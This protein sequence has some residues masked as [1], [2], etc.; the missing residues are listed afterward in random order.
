MLHE[1]RPDVNG[2][3]VRNVPMQGDEWIDECV[4]FD[5]FVLFCSGPELFAEGEMRIE[6]EKVGETTLLG[7]RERAPVF[8]IAK[9]P[10]GSIITSRGARSRTSRL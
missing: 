7:S 6:G 10:R 4:V 9:L 1:K 2:S 8:R 3:F 5:F